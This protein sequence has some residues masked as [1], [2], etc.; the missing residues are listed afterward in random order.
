MRSSHILLIGV[1]LALF[2][3]LQ[4][5]I[6]VIIVVFLSDAQ[7]TLLHLAHYMGSANILRLGFNFRFEHYKVV[8][9]IFLVN[10]RAMLG[11]I[12]LEFWQPASCPVLL[13]ILFEV[14]VAIL[15]DVELACFN[16][17]FLILLLLR[18]NEVGA[19]QNVVLHPVLYTVENEGN[20]H[21]HH[22]EFN[23]RMPVKH[24]QYVDTNSDDL[25]CEIVLKPENGQ[26]GNSDDHNPND[27]LNEPDF[28]IDVLVQ[29]CVRVSVDVLRVM[30]RQVDSTLK[31]QNI[32]FLGV[33]RDDWL[34]GDRQHHTEQ[35]FAN[36]VD[37]V[38][39][40]PVTFVHFQL[41]VDGESDV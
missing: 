2:K 28:V 24:Q 26:F 3:S 6:S 1:G 11:I 22:K 39:V 33:V 14:D 4:I 27:Q 7:R 15:H 8:F 38:P 10:V 31:N 12:L 37:E 23:H 19:P 13:P 41:K 25:V 36:E 32:V 35:N 30:D 40:T 20:N 21:H 18:L 16:L 29:I 9:H 5:Q 34:E 17:I